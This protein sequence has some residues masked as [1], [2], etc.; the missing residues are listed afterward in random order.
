MLQI[1]IL[2]FTFSSFD[3]SHKSFYHYKLYKYFRLAQY[4]NGKLL[5]CPDRR[6]QHKL[7]KQLLVFHFRRTCKDK[8]RGAKDA[9]EI[10]ERN[11]V[12]V[13]EKDG[14]GRQRRF[15]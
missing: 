3:R 15:S 7:I 13:E 4:C 11:R 12:F 9:L 6:A 10:Y 5:V 14:A 8:R 2:C 1:E